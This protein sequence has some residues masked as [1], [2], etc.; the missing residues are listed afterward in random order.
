MRRHAPACAHAQGRAGHGGHQ[1]AGG[2][3]LGQHDRRRG[4]ALRASCTRR[5]ARSQRGAWL[6]AA[7]CV[8]HARRPAPSAVRVQLPVHALRVGGPGASR[9][10]RCHARAPSKGCARLICPRGAEQPRHAAAQLPAVRVPRVQRMRAGAHS[11]LRPGCARSSCDSCAH[12][13]DVRLLPAVQLYNFQRWFRSSPAPP[14]LP[15]PA[16]AAA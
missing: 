15:A 10:S 6:R 16:K 8:A 2:E 7:R 9:C 12:A 3:H 4:F 1:E 14:A 13:T 11:A 5:S